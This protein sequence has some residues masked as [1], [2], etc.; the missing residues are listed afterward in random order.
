MYIVQSTVAIVTE[1][2]IINTTFQYESYN[3]IY[4]AIYS[5]YTHQHTLTMPYVIANDIILY[6]INFV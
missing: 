5:E 3:K 4:H 1:M 6:Q 2:Y